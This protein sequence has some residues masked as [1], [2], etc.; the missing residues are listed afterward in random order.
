MDAV[1]L[2]TTFRT[3]PSAAL[4]EVGIIPYHLTESTREEPP[5]LPL[6]KRFSILSYNIKNTEFKIT[7]WMV[8]ERGSLEGHLPLTLGRCALLFGRTSPERHCEHERS[9]QFASRTKA[10]GSRGRTCN[11]GRSSSEGRIPAMRC[12]GVRGG[13]GSVRKETSP[14][15]DRKMFLHQI[16]AVGLSRTNAGQWG[17][18]PARVHGLG[19][20]TTSHD[21]S[22][23]FTPRAMQ[24]TPSNRATASRELQILYGVL[25]PLR[26][27]EAPETSAM[28]RGIRE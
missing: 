21:V 14:L 23:F 10:R 9:A 25:S 5:T 19:V 8:L 2:A 4:T 18:L 15:S 11:D 12:D 28:K 6:L 27:L 24:L 3:H 22:V 20:R 26:Q 16:P 7:F 1:H 13:S 17:K